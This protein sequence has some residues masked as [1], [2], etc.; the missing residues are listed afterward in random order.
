[1]SHGGYLLF[2]LQV[3]AVQAKRFA[4]PETQT[5]DASQKI[6]KK[7]SDRTFAASATW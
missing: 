6:G 4:P 1:M 3:A 5:F 7:D 2:N